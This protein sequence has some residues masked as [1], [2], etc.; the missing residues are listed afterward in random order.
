MVLVPEN[1]VERLQQRQHIL[2]PPVTQTLKTLDSE[3]EDIL[4]SEKLDDEEK[5]KLYNQAS[6]R[7]LIYYDQ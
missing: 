1:T 4:A 6:Q 2:T 5:A 7:Y 3:M